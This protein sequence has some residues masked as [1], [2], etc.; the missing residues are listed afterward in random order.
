MLRDSYPIYVVIQ[1]PTELDELVLEKFRRL[2]KEIVRVKSNSVDKE[3][4]INDNRLLGWRKAFIEHKHKYVLCVEDDVEISRDAID[5]SEAVI[6]Q[7]EN[8]K[9]F[10]GINYGSFEVG[11]DTNSYS[12]LRYGVHGPASL[13]SLETYKAM[14]PNLLRLLNGKI[15]WDS[16]IEPITKSGYMCTSNTSRYKDNG[17]IGTHTSLALDEAYF[18]KL[19]NSYNSTKQKRQDN[20]VHKQIDHSWRR[21]CVSYIPEQ[22]FVYKFRIACI[23]IVQI[24]NLCVRNQTQPD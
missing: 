15:A 19:E 4:L 8:E 13:I 22:K 16:W 17:L 6:Q 20:Y 21:D 23:R 14:K 7:N 10:R 2:I 12:K 5:F 9:D 1:D 11:N 24:K 3:K 18:S